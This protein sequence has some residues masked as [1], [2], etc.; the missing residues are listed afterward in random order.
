[1]RYHLDRQIEVLQAPRNVRRGRALRGA[2]RVWRRRSAE[3]RVPRRTWAAP[4]RKLSCR[5]RAMRSARSAGRPASQPSRSCRCPWALARTR[6]SSRSS[7][8]CCSN[9][10]R[11]HTP[12]ASSSSASSRWRRTRRLPST[13]RTSSPG[14]RVFARSRRSRSPSGPRSTCS[15]AD[16]AEQVSSA[17]VTP[18]LFRVFGLPPVGRARLHGRR[19]DARKRAGRHSRLS[20]SGSGASAAVAR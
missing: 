4:P 6:R 20:A 11:S 10:C 2:A 18:D 19:R 13:R 1:M 16:G 8:R 5:T 7:T 3:G 15:A 12:I 17:N 14:A 9:R